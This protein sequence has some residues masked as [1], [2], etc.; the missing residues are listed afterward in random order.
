MTPAPTW[1]LLILGFGTPVVFIVSVVLG[2]GLAA[3]M[4]RC[5]ALACA[6]LTLARAPLWLANRSAET[7]SKLA[8]TASLAGIFGWL[9]FF[10]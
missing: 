7:I 2:D 8:A 1:A 3:A 4:L 9:G 10:R 5:L 6:V